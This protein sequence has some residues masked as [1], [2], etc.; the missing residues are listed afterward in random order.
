MSFRDMSS[1]DE[2]TRLGAIPAR[3]TVAERDADATARGHSQGYSASDVEQLQLE[4][5]LREAEA[6]ERVDA[7]NRYSQKL[8]AE[9]GFLQVGNDRRVKVFSSRVT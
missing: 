8:E 4:V 5:E 9:V 2:E 3:R 6:G 7:A 1:D